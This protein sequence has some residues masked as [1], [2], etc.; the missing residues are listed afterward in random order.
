VGR[1]LVFV[2]L[3]V[4]AAA[5]LTPQYGPL[6]TTP[7]CIFCGS[8]GGVDFLLNVLLFFP[9]GVALA[10]CNRHVAAAV[11]AI[12]ALSIGIETT[13]LF[14]I[15]GRDASLGDVLANSCGGLIGFASTRRV[16][17]WVKPSGK[18]ALVLSAAWAAVWLA[19]Q[20]GVSY[21]L[22]PEFP[23]TRYYGQIARVFGY[24]APFEGQVLSATVD[25]I[26]VPNSGYA[27]T[28]ML[29]AA[30]ESG[31][32]VAAKVV[33]AEP[34][35]KIA[36][37][38]RIAGEEKQEITILAQDHTALVFG[39]H[40][41]AQTLRLRAAFYAMQNVFPSES[42]SADTLTLSG[43]DSRG[44][45]TLSASS[46]QLTESR[47]LVLSPA[48]G[49]TLISPVRWYLEG[50]PWETAIGFLWIA[51]LVIPFGYWT[52]H[53]LLREVSSAAKLTCVGALLA[54]LVAGLMWIP[55]RFGL[56]PLLPGL[57]VPAAAGLAC[58]ALL[59]SFSLQRV[60]RQR[61]EMGGEDKRV[62]SP[63]QVSQV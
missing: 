35:P 26:S 46:S 40:V 1:L 23:T 45:V 54:T 10:L 62:A 32:A 20:W 41:G 34:T 47:R 22:A 14:F 48:M 57:V 3:L 24:M 18:A 50:T 56:Q 33:P 4:I 19:V 52:T 6:E 11:A 53:A 63:R 60:S 17:T 38:L 29:R 27:K 8:L 21:G 55:H 13:Q 25:T 12:V 5:T 37:I 39:V 7:Y 36:P 61:S 2:S 59:A 30:L 58:G 49:W 15:A 9:M 31:G 42:I 28:A 51:C 16:S 44:L 43:A